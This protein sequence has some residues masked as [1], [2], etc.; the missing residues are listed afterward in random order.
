METSLAAPRLADLASFR[1]ELVSH[2]KAHLAETSKRTRVKGLKLIR[3]LPRPLRTT[4]VRGA[5]QRLLGLEVRDHVPDE[6]RQ[7]LPK[8][9]SHGFIEYI[10]SRII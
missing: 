8:W 5:H 2:H 9:I 1:P 7:I 3:H 10:E 6:G 4:R